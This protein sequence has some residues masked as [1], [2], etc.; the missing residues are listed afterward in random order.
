MKEKS[1]HFTMVFYTTLALSV[2]ACAFTYGTVN[3]IVT[4]INYYSYNGIVFIRM[5]LA[6]LIM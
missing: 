6:A 5:L 4:C 2:T 1:L 3:Y